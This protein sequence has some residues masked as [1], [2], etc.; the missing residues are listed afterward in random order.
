[1]IRKIIFVIFACFSILN[2]HER[3]FTYSYD[4]DYL[5]KGLFE[6]EQWTTLKTG[7]ERGFYYLWDMRTEFE[8]AITEKTHLALYL[9]YSST[10]K[11]SYENNQVTEQS[12]FKFKGIDL[13][14]VHRLLSPR[15]IIGFGVYLE[16]KYRMN[17]QEIE[18]KILL[19]KYFG[20]ILWTLNFIFE[21]E[22]EGK[23][24][25]SGN[26]ETEK[27]AKFILPI[28]IAYKF[29]SFSFG[30]EAWLHSEFKDRILPFTTKAEHHAFFLGPVIHYSTSKFWIT[31]TIA[32][33]ITKVLDEHE[34]L[35]SRMI[36]S[37]IF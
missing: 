30:I 3:L 31:L 18:E 6:L 12:T 10:Y 22:F 16:G 37:I 25:S 11:H 2:A 32:P 29:G 19:S 15:D 27:E 24:S 8:Y 23:Y 35:E 17:K 1:M 21:Q 9:N 36:F 20:S 13:A 26:I 7:K 5:P 34:K 28:G 14:V 33:Q 4:T